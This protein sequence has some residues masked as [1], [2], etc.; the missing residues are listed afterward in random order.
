M[1]VHLVMP[2]GGAGSRF[3]VNGFEMPKPLIMIKNKP[4]FYWATMS[5]K[6]YVDLEDLTFVVLR[7]HVNKFNIDKEILNYFSEAKIIIIEEVLPGPVFTSLTGIKNINDNLPI[8]F[9]DCDHMFKCS[10][11]NN[12]LNV[13]EMSIDGGLFTFES[14]KPQYS[15]IKYDINNKIVGTVEKK[16]VSN[17]S[18]CVAYLFK[19]VNIFRRIANEY[20]DNCPY[21]E[22]YMSG[23]YSIMC[24]KGMIVKDYLLDFH[25]EFGT[26]E[27][28][29]LAKESK[30]FQ[31]IDSK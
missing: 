18:I 6:K 21:N 26:P 14:N 24:E 3:K 10:E 12:L 13:K 25:L 23:L 5:I 4:F 19:N 16:V 1:K 20:I 17:H 22:C 2:M 28:Y 27:E 8:I 7:D 30:Y 11:I 29:E 31:V 15:Y 9:N